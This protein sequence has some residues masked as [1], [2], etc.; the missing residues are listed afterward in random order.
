MWI[1]ELKN[2]NAYRNLP[3]ASGVREVLLHQ[4]EK[5]EALRKRKG[6]KFK[7]TG[8]Y[9]GL[10]FATSVGSPV[11]KYVIENALNLLVD[12]INENESVIAAIEGREPVI[13]EHLYPHALRH[14]YASLCYKVGVD[15]KTLQKLMGHEKI[16]TTLDIYTHLD[17]ELW[18]S[19]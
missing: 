13:F 15:P 4:K 17:S 10:V 14:T 3:M 7:C 11:T 12:K 8:E 9:E 19:I 2:K 6:D 5:M 16:S 18:Y 1:G